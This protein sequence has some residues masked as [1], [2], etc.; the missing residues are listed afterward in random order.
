MG[1][2]WRFLTSADLG[3][4]CAANFEHEEILVKVRL[5]LLALS[6]GPVVARAEIPQRPYPAVVYRFEQRETPIP[7]K[8]YV[9]AIDLSNPNVRVR[10]ARGG[11][12]PDGDGKWQT[13]LMRPSAIAE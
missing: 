7:Q 11:A 4:P 8:I 5:L 12:D 1:G 6:L 13:T 10:V 9:A 3:L 2:V